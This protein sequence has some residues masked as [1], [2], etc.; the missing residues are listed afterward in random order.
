[1]FVDNVE[2]AGYLKLTRVSLSKHKPLQVGILPTNLQMKIVR[3][4]YGKLECLRLL[5]DA[6]QRN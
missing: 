5:V 3:L 4:D 6:H 1:M 2:F